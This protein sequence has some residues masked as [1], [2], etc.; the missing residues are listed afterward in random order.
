MRLASSPA[1]PAGHASRSAAQIIVLLSPASACQQPP[2]RA[3]A[4]LLPVYKPRRAQLLPHSSLFFRISQLP[5]QSLPACQVGDKHANKRPHSCTRS[6]RSPRSDRQRGVSKL[7]T[8]QPSAQVLYSD[9]TLLHTGRS[10]DHSQPNRRA[11]CELGEICV[12][13]SMWQRLPTRIPPVRMLL[14]ITRKQVHRSAQ[15]DPVQYCSRAAPCVPA[16]VR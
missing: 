9:C 8:L 4:P 1:H 16:C 14:A 5:L 11:T 7:S 12:P 15:H 3:P 6:P 10:L 13:A 2:P